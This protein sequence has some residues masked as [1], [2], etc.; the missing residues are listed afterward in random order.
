MNS[1]KTW[2][3]TQLLHCYQEK[4]IHVRIVNDIMYQFVEN[5]HGEPKGP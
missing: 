4:K 2:N 1:Y 5:Y 3:K